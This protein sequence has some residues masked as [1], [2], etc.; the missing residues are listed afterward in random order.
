M[1]NRED[2]IGKYIK[3]IDNNTYH[4]DR[5]FISSSQL[6][7]AIADHGNYRWEMN[8]PNEERKWDKDDAMNLGTAFH[9]MVL[10]PELYD[11]EISHIDIEGLNLRTKAD[12]ITLNKLLEH[13][14][15]K[16]I[17]PNTSKA[18][19]KIMHE[20]LLGHPFA[21][22][23]MEA[24]GEPEM[25]GYF[26]DDFYKID[27]RFRPDKRINDFEGHPAI[28]DLKTCHNMDDFIKTAKWRLH[29]NL[30]AHMYL[31][32]EKYING[33]IDVPF[34][35]VV[36]ETQAPYRSAVFKCSDQFL[37]DGAKKYRNALA[38]VKIARGLPADTIRYQE[39]DYQEI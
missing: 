32:G 27:L 30:S 4:A 28:M 37:M 5:D 12:K 36:Q 6:K 34:F 10:E 29:Y 24:D 15:G 19:L 2:K 18:K 8:K 20:A 25:S 35:F 13:H 1:M 21:R 33:N 38:N 9:S 26:T 39:V 17:L 14:K 11:E 3:G 23:L 16:V 31:E 7:Y 22:K